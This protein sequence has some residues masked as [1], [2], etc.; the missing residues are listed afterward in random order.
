V[1][2][3]VDNGNVMGICPKCKAN[4]KV[5]VS[6]RGGGAEEKAAGAR[7]RPANPASGLNSPEN[8]FR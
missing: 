5:P 4:L 8:G 2:I 1:L 6:F 3:F 7:K